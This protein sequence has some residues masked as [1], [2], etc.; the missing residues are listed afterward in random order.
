MK[1]KETRDLPM[2][3]VRASFAP[4]SV[5][6]E[7]RTVELVW[8][9]GAK[10]L[11][12]SF[13]SGERWYE[14]LSL[15]PKHVRMDRLNG[16][17]PLLNTHSQWDLGDVLG[18]VER[19]WLKD[20]EGRAVV[21]FS[22]RED[23]DRVFT[24]VADGII[25]NV[26]VGYKIHKM[27][28]IRSNDENEPDTYRAVDWEPMEL[29]LVPVPFDAGAQVRGEKPAATYPV[30]IVTRGA[31]EGDEPGDE[32]TVHNRNPENDMS[33]ETPV[34]A[35]PTEDQIRAEAAAAERTRVAEI[36]KAVRA[37]G[38][39]QA[40]A[41]KM[42]EDA[43]T[44]DAARAAI[45]DELAKRQS[46]AKPNAV[47][48]EVV[49][50][51]TATRREM[52]INALMHRYDPKVQLLDG[53]RGFRGMSL[54]R[55]AEELLIARGEDVRGLSR[56]ELAQRA[57]HSTSD[58]P[59]ILANVANKTLRAAY[60]AAPQTFRP[61]VRVVSA[62]DF[63]TIQRT[64]LGDAPSLDKVNESGEFKRGTIGEGKETY[65]LLTYG[66]IVGITRQTIINDDLD[67][68]TR[69]PAMFGR[70]AADKESDLVW[71]V[72]TA[73]AAMADGTALFHADH[74]NLAGSNGAI[75]VDTLGTGRAAMRKQTGLNGRYI[76]VMPEFLAVPAAKE[77]IAQQFLATERIVNK[78]SEANPFAGSL[79]LLVEPRLDANSATAWYLFAS[80]SQIDTIELAYLEG[81]QGVY[82]ET[83]Q[84]F[85]V[86]GV[87]IKARLDVATKAIDHR[88]MYKNAGA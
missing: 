86:D 87:E 28:R 11:R 84:G 71:G 52:A 68:F 81:N 74:G 88:G 5:D 21:R 69:I 83:R 15:D 37:A 77:T 4:D 17:A 7:A 27:E 2:L 62:P 55:M 70:A 54:L 67:A 51:E 1:R 29:S 47:R 43:V 33:K 20:G 79:Q 44:V 31:A 50:D 59:Y 25:R 64:Q 34:V 18:V 41:D 36:N 53:A 65:N 30:E 66:K 82:I 76:N 3:D 39:D 63:K 78:S 85:D 6:R 22:K 58:F 48:V 24:D 10:G 35:Q 46:T 45:I 57:L 60:E 38:L 8:T 40:V 73:N 23:A 56:M 13:W 14:E 19:A 61:I 16:G 9:T 32:P 26:S 75:S 42:I 80:P 49:R 72:I 12:S